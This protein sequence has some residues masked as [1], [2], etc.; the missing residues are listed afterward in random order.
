M[1]CPPIDF[2]FL[3]DLSGSYADDLP[4]FVNSA[5]NIAAS[6]RLIDPNSQFAIASFIDLPVSPYGAPGD[7]LYNADLPLTD[8]ISTLKL[9][10]LAYQFAM[11]F[12]IPEA[13]YVGLWRAANGV[14]LNLR[15]NSRKI[16]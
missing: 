11:E 6:V 1:G 2:V 10:F 5:R 16:I 8:S 7:Y 13:Q 14:G 12:D 4:N 3:N 15:E 9:P